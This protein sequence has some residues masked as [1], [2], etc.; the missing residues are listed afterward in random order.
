M[1]TLSKLFVALCFITGFSLQGQDS[2]T[3]DQPASF[4]LE[5]ARAYALSHNKQLKN[6]RLDIEIADQQYNEARGQGLPQVSGQLDYMTNFN[7]EATFE[8]GAGNGDMPDI[9]YSKLDAGDFEILKIL[10]QMASPGATT[11]VMT[12]QSNAQVQV[13]QLIFSG[14][15]WV[16]LQT[17]GIARELARESVNITR[18]DVLENVTNTYQLILVT[19]SIIEVMEESIRAMEEIKEHT[20]NMYQA[21]VAEETD[22]DQL[23]VTLSGIENQKRALERNIN[24]SYNMLRFQLGL[25]MDHELI[26]TDSLPG[27]L[28]NLTGLDH[29]T[30]PLQVDQNPTY[31]IIQK[32]EQLQEK[33]VDM[34]RWA[35]GPTLT[36]FYSYTEK[37]K[38]T[39]FD[40]APN[41]AAGVQLNVPIF[42][43]G[44]RKARLEKAK[45]ELEQANRAK[46]MTEEQL[47][48]QDNQLRY[49]LA[50][51]YEN[52]RTQAQNIRIAR[53][54]Q[55]S[56][57]RK[58]RQGMVS[59]MELTQSNANYLEAESNYLSAVLE[60]LQA[61]T[62][63]NK[64]YNNL[65]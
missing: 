8:M 52:Y 58:Y 36:G 30:T 45:L 62:R 53:R 40:L 57:S 32:Q 13:S 44:V 46:E 22:V 18:L 24:L 21:G 17:A 7:Y 42:S 28:D 60:L 61:N 50:S 39:G 9:D 56:V 33:M 37:I 16:G 55:E 25:N 31:Q 14:Q 65:E 4:S 19:E 41:N 23:T 59:A 20:V 10:Q 43:S 6:A 3:G 34:E 2:G 1:R 11:I 47:R 54:L 29:V 12:D 35:F 26:L 49:E 51:A 48:L 27:I 38:T 5:Q 15:Y 63:I 64:L